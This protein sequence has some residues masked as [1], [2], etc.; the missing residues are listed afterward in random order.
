MGDEIDKN[1]SNSVFAAIDLALAAIGF[2]PVATLIG[3]VG[4]TFSSIQNATLIENLYAFFSSARK[5]NTKEREKFFADLGA[6]KERFIRNIII[7][8]DRMN[9]MK[10]SE[11]IG[12]LF[13]NLVEGY[14]LKEEFVRLC[15]VIEKVYVDDLYALKDKNSVIHK[16]QK[17]QEVEEPMYIQTLI[18]NGLLQ[19]AKPAVGIASPIKYEVTRLGNVFIRYS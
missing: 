5:A 7:A 17:F 18:A 2:L 8:I 6:D 1:A 19:N 10:K 11:M 14:F 13:V 3:A 16:I 15:F 4:N 12:N 9:D